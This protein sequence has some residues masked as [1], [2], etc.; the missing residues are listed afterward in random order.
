MSLSNS[1]NP[2]RVAVFARDRMTCRYCGLLT[3]YDDWAGEIP[4]LDHVTP[5]KQGGLDTIENLVLACRD[6][7]YRKK[8]RTPEQAGMPLRDPPPPVGSV[9]RGGSDALHPVSGAAPAWVG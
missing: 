9:S 3:H 7:N 8:G 1:D 6:C 2:L 4:T 5:K